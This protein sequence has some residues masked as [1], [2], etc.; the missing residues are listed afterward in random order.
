[1]QNSL[2]YLTQLN[3][4]GYVL[5]PDYTYENIEYKFDNVEKDIYVTVN[6]DKFTITAWTIEVNGFAPIELDINL[7]QLFINFA[8]AKIKEMFE[9]MKGE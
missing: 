1:M 6:V 8:N 7:Y 2:L 5:N 3:E 9:L 4:L